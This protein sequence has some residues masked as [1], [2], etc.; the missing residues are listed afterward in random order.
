[1]H[2]GRHVGRLVLHHTPLG[3]AAQAAWYDARGMRDSASTPTPVPWR[4][5]AVLLATCGGLGRVGFA[6]GTFGSIVGIPLSLATGWLATASAAPFGGGWPAVA[7]EAVLVAAV[8]LVAVPIC[9]RAARRLGRGDD[10]GAIVIDEV[11]AVPLALL[12]V[13]FADRSWAALAAGFVL[14]R[15]FD[16]SKPFPCRR[17][18]TLP[19]GLGIMADDWGAAAWT[20]TCLAVARW[21]HWI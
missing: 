11:V 13:P 5:P 1:M 20:A 21:Q 15:L 4:D 7:V 19:A 3:E 17:L 14:F 12:A 2:R 9:T 6:P 18:E 10:P 8:C 16:I